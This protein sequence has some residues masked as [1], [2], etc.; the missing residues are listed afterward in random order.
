MEGLGWR[1]ALVGG[2][3]ALHVALFALLPQ[4]DSTG[5]A[6]CPIFVRLSP[7]PPPAAP[8]APAPAPPPVPAAQP[9]P[10]SVPEEVRT[11]WRMAQSLPAKPASTLPPVQP[12]AP[13]AAPAEI[14]APAPPAESPGRLA[15]LGTT[16]H[17]PAANE[18]STGGTPET[19]QPGPGVP[20]ALPARPAPAG[21][22][23]AGSVDLKALLRDFSAGVSSRIRQHQ[24]YPDSAQ[25]A[26]QEGKVKV[27]FTVGSDG[28]LVDAVVTDSSGF[29]ELDAAALAAVRAAAPFAPIPA[30]LNR[31]SA[32]LSITLRFF[33]K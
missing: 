17:G 31:S 12:R 11:P 7:P 6:H 8:L 23:A 22:D 3:L 25:R 18:G 16:G 27:S 32:R 10:R 24:H 13:A 15:G 14:P 2:T 1:I 21:S 20:T 33:L 9:Q 4:I 19:D 5:P 26:G 30:E 28:R 29:G